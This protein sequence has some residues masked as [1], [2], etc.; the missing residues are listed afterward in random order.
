MGQ[1]AIN[2]GTGEIV[3]AFSISDG[4]W[5]TLCEAPRGTLLMPRSRWPAVPKTSIRGIRYFAHY[6]GYTGVLPKPESYAHIRL[7][8]DIVRIAR[9]LGY[10]AELE[11]AGRT[12]EGSEWIADVLVSKPTGEKYAFEVQLSSQHLRDFRARTRRYRHSNVNCC[13]IVSNKPVDL[14]L[15]KAL[16]HENM[17]YYREH[18]EFLCDD[19]ELLLF[20]VELKDKDSYPA[21]TPQLRFSRGREMRKMPMDEAVH[22]VLLG[23]PKWHRPS[24]H[25]G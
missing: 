7:K 18:G 19:E 20:G 25:W 11:A 4:V 12:P 14:R 1:I 6:P 5:Q 10:E 15:V 13:W 3:E 16:S 21:D 2:S 17:D 22:G 8:I 23:F 24:W 9:A